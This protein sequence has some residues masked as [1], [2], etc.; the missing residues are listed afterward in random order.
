MTVLSIQ[1]EGV[2]ENIDCVLTQVN[3]CLSKYLNARRYPFNQESREGSLL[4]R[5]GGANP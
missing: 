5:R 4:R 1:R 3:T 2:G